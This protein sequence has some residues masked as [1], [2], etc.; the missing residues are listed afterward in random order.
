MNGSAV[1]IMPCAA[2]LRVHTAAD[3]AAVERD[4]AEL[5]HAAEGQSFFLAPWWWRTMLSAGLPPG[6]AAR[7][8]ICAD[9]K[10]PL[11]VLPLVSH[12]DGT[13]AGL[14]GP[15]TCLFQPLFADHLD[16]ASLQCIGT[17]FARHCSTFPPIR[18]DALDA[19]APWLAPFLAGAR[20]V[21]LHAARFD[22]FGNWYEPVGGIDW[23]TYLRARPGGLR[24]TIRRKMRHA[25]ETEFRL[26]TGG[27]ALEPAI[28]AYQEVYARSWKTAEPYPDFNAA[29]M[30]EAAGA[31]ALR[32]GLLYVGAQIIAAQLWIVT[33]G[34]AA[35]LKL[36]HDEGY[37]PL[38]PGTVLSVHMIRHLLERE[39]VHTLDFGRGDDAYKQL[40]TTR[41]RQRIGVI[42]A[43]PWR[44]TGAAILL[45]H[46]MGQWRRSWAVRP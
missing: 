1:P 29:L 25:G 43:N 26:M 46:H 7:F 31:G 19:D 33:N 17:A 11:A 23:A 42:L 14:S 5:L 2:E 22:H 16:V 6:S 38:S 15:Y 45:R 8:L 18:L 27:D 44:P 13:L 34:T 20:A 40:W 4:C 28:A 41:R 37:K 3:F 32:L 24:E 39:R 36:A 35:V 10:T 9:A 12:A 21:G 30:R